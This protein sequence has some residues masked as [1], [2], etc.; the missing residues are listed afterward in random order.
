MNKNVK[1]STF[2][3]LLSAIRKK[4]EDGR[5]ILERDVSN[6]KT[7]VMWRIS[8]YIH[9]HILEYSEKA[10]YGDYLFNKLAEELGKNK[11]TLYVNS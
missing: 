10:D 8:S 3:D 1:V 5:V 7:T 9:T 4:I 6:R 2:N 11:R